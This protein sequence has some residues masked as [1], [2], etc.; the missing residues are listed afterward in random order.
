VEPD[1]PASKFQ[2]RDNAI[3]TQLEATKWP[4]FAEVKAAK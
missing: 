1:E 4:N 3:K 2:Q